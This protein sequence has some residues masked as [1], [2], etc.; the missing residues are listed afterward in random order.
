[1]TST[2][3]ATIF[4]KIV[5]LAPS[6]Y[7]G[8]FFRSAASRSASQPI[9]EPSDKEVY[10]DSDSDL[11]VLMTWPGRPAV[12]HSNLNAGSARLQPPALP[13]SPS[14]NRQTKW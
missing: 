3:L 9:A 6:K 7:N 2:A 14:R 13:V 8:K 1:M 5:L 4:P 12:H 10:L 11:L